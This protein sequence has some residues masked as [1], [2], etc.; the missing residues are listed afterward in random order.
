LLQFLDIQLARSGNHPTF[1]G[2]G[3][4]NPTSNEVVGIG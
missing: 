4:K 3:Y 2:V 1:L